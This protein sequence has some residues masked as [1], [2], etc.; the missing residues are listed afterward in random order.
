M[1]G[2]MPSIV[3]LSTNGTLSQII[4][5]EGRYRHDLL[6]QL[7]F[8]VCNLQAPVTRLP[9]LYFALAAQC[10][11]RQRNEIVPTIFSVHS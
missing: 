1:M 11:T 2:R 4:K 7:G 6:K 5:G 9:A 3:L 10:Y 8:Q